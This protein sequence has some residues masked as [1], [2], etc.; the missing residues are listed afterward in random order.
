MVSTET[1][2]FMLKT[3]FLTDALA[4]V[5]ELGPLA[6][7]SWYAEPGKEDTKGLECGCNT[8]IYRL[9]YPGFTFASG[10]NRI[11]PSSLYSACTAC[12]N[13]PTQAWTKWNQNCDVVYES[14]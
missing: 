13:I 2:N 14:Q 7:D 1:V 8:I 6:P 9:V 3:S 11:P 12:Q 4:G 5:Y 10:D